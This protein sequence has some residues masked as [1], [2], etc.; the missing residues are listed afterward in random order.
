VPA[1]TG[2]REEEYCLVSIIISGVLS[3]F[4]IHSQAI[5]VASEGL[6]AFGGQGYIEDTG[7]PSLL[8]DAQASYGIEMPFHVCLCSRGQVISHVSVVWQNAKITVLSLW[9]LL[10]ETLVA[11]TRTWVFEYYWL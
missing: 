6:E 9:L 11:V 4:A 10:I 7:L 1:P 5:L 8:R 2:G 3:L